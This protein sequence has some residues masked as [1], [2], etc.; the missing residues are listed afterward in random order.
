MSTLLIQTERHVNVSGM[1]NLF[2]ESQ[3]KELSNMKGERKYD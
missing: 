2:Y 3:L 1:D